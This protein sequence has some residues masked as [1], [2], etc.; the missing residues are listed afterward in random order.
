MSTPLPGPVQAVVVHNHRAVHIQKRSIVRSCTELVFAGP[1]H[2][3]VAVDCPLVIAARGRLDVLPEVI[4]VGI[5]DVRHLGFALVIQERQVLGVMQVAAWVV[6]HSH[7]ELRR[8][9]L[10]R[11]LA[12]TFAGAVDV[13]A[14]VSRVWA[15]VCCSLVDSATPLEALDLNFVVTPSHSP[16]AADT[17]RT[18]QAIVVHNHVAIQKQARAVVRGAAP[19]VLSSSLDVHHTVKDPCVVAGR[20]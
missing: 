10:R 1:L 6:I 17:A 12:R 5:L 3:E 15:V 8:G 14:A 7:E 19:S 11:Q 9:W 16:G 18:V 4:Q 2:L 13:H 20:R